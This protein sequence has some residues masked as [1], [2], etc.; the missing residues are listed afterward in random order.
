VTGP[1]EAGFR[2]RGEQLLW[3]G[4]RFQVATVDVQAPEGEGLAREV[5]RHP[6]AVAA[7]PLHDDG[8]VTL[9]RQYRAALDRVIWEIP[10]GL[11]DVDGEATEVTAG[12][13]LAEE[14]GLQA[15]ELRHLIT[16]HNSAGFADEATVI[17]LATGL[18]PVPHDRQGP[19][20]RHMAVERVGL[21]VA[22]GMVDDGTITDAK[23]V[24]GLL[25]TARRT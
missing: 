20:E 22:L 2:V 25:L 4:R 11:R 3:R 8:T 5:L 23:T 19:E 16:F 17:Y 18:S 9:I 1:G 13:E 24:I 7:V 14:V 10:A 21:D 15:T 6:G 12:R